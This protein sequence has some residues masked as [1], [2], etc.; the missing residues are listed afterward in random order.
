MLLLLVSYCIPQYRFIFTSL[1]YNW[2][3]G[4]LPHL[5]AHKGRLSKPNEH[6]IKNQQW[7]KWDVGCLSRTQFSMFCF[8]N[9]WQAL[10]R[11]L[12]IH[13]LTKDCGDYIK[14]HRPHFPNPLR[15]IPSATAAMV[16]Q[17]RR[18]FWQNTSASHRMGR[19]MSMNVLSIKHT[20]IFIPTLY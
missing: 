6:T 15:N 19:K 9:R 7:V 12:N 14:R 1:I 16:T 8:Q 18:R 13:T 11:P 20:L 5:W 4:E 10:H 17:T 3:A 2:R